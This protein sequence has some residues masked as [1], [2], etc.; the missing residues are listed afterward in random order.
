MNKEQIPH[1]AIKRRFFEEAEVNIANNENQANGSNPEAADS[2]EGDRSDNGLGTFDLGVGGIP[3]R[4]GVYGHMSQK[5]N[6]EPEIAANNHRKNTNGG[7][8]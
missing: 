4:E 3:Q 8:V 2:Q 7:R 5:R 1:H 6:E